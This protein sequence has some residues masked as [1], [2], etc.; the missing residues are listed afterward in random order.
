MQS[1][2][3]SNGLEYQ[4]LNE[5]VEISGKCL[6]T[7]KPYKVTISKEGFINWIN[8]MLIQDAIPY[9][10]EGDREF[11]SSKVSPAGRDNRLLLNG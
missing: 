3:L 8:G 6:I 5:R 10:N 1:G 7:S 9:L 2:K 11:L 4:I